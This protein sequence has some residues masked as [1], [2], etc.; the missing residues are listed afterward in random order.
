MYKLDI[1]AHIMVAKNNGSVLS[2]VGSIEFT[3]R[4]PRSRSG[5]VPQTLRQYLWRQL[6]RSIFIIYGSIQKHAAHSYVGIWVIMR[7]RI[8]KTL[9]DYFAAGIS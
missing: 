9:I 3:L 2:P 5:T 1:L 7:N 8:V 6:T 4:C